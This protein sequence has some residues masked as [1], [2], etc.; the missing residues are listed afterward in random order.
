MSII[1]VLLALLLIHVVCTSAISFT[2]SVLGL[3]RLQEVKREAMQTNFLA[4]DM[5]AR[6]WR[7]AGYSAAG[8]PIDGVANAAVQSVE[9]RAD[10]DGDGTTAGLHERIAYRWDS[11]RSAVT[12]ATQNASPQPWL[13]N[14]PSDGFVL[15]YFD[16]TGTPVPSEG[17]SNSSIGFMRL[18]LTTEW[19]A[20]LPEPTL[21][22]TVATCIATARRNR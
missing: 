22:G 3:L 9:L 5:L 16:P 12:R 18:Q 17:T 2:R 8:E 1:E 20:Q 19:A 7:I 14:V 6:E 11:G 4:L 15:T 13:S 10:L 21:R